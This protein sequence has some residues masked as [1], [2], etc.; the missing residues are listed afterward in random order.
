MDLKDIRIYKGRNI[1]CLKPVIRLTV[2]LTPAENAPTCQVPGFN[3]R[4]LELFPGLYRHQCALGHEGGFVERLREGTYPGHVAEHTI[5]ELQGLLGYDVTFGTTRQEKGTLDYHIVY[6]YENE[7][8]GITCGKAVI[9]LMNEL[10]QGKTVDFAPVLEDL[11]ALK[12]RTDM[13]PST[14]AI[15]EE[16]L[17]RGIPV[18]RLGADSQLQLGYGKYA[19]RMEAAL[20]DK[21]SCIA[22]N[23]AGDK[24]LTK[25][26]LR[27]NGIP[28]P[29]GEIAY[30]LDSALRCAGEIG[31]PVVVKPYDSNHGNGVTLNIESP[32]EIPDAFEKAMGF[33]TAAIVEKYIHGRDY[34]VL[35]VGGKVSA[36][37][38]RKPPFVTGDGVSTIQQLVD[39]ENE[40]PLR[41]DDHTKPLTKIT[42]DETAI[43][44][45]TEQNL[46][47]DSV[48]GAGVTV[49]LRKNANL[50]TGGTARSCPQEIHPDNAASAVKAAQILG[51]DIAGVDV[52]SP[53]ISVPLKENHGA[54]IEVNAGPGLRMHV[55]P[56]EGPPA[57]VAKDILDMLYPLGAPYTIPLVAVTGTN[58]KTTV[59]R[60]IAHTL[61]LTGRKVGYTTTSGIYLN[62]VCLLK[63]DNTGALSASLVLSHPETEAAVL[64][65]ARGGI[66]R[67]GL[68]Y[69]LSDVGVITNVTEDHLGLDGID[70]V[71]DLAYV[72]ALVIEAVKPRGCAVLNADDPMTPYFLERVKC[73]VFLFSRNINTPL[74][75]SHLQQGGN[76]AFFH[77]GALHVQYLNQPSLL[78]KVEEVPITYGGTAYCNIE[79]ALAACAA[80]MGLG[81][82]LGAIRRGLTTF[83]PD[84][85]HNPGRFNIFEGNGF[86]VMLDYGHNIAGY[87]QTISFLER[88]GARRL[89][90]IIGVPGDRQD[91]AIQKI[92][93]LC[94]Q[95][96]HKLYIKE[97]IDLRGRKSGIVAGLLK[98]T[99]IS[100][101]PH[102]DLQVCLREEDALRQALDNA[103]PGDFITVFYEHYEPLKALIQSHHMAERPVAGP[104][105][106]ATRSTGISREG[107]F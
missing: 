51:L 27:R 104:A 103:Q 6:R 5:L 92:G 7:Q 98:D 24:H 28:V 86:K 43:D 14:R 106:Q 72:K 52:C 41:G 33:S 107:P 105:G 95:H 23:T 58:G 79:N 78:M 36:V 93:A 59:V 88:Q 46:T 62:D 82:P 81:I 55:M 101:N 38:E 87:E 94:A 17:R 73:N 54:I 19:R 15:Y 69:D 35:V 12:A 68:G 22:V 50:S 30:S 44:E 1:H 77:E 45:L 39:K 53:D 83:A 74:L 34:R 25:E 49:P 99:A 84:E 37:A 102:I 90:G 8:V 91:S 67:R 57:Q 29:T 89:V 18:T 40:N 32:E 100:A 13:G 48:P 76:A 9:S 56:S 26:L 64:E 10:M 16:A 61:V 31:Y 85:K 2:R 3:D 97:D 60:L 65:T 80:L 21:P 47:P 71:E 66:V 42:L 4:L 96:F 70:T 11:H 63:G 20:S 75:Q